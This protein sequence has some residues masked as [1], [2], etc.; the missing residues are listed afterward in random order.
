MSTCVGCGNTI[1]IGL[2]PSL[3]VL[4]FTCIETGQDETEMIIG[5]MALVEHTLRQRTDNKSRRIAAHI[6]TCCSW[7]RTDQRHSR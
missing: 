5:R 1:D 4:C 3:S 2:V 6:R 7:I